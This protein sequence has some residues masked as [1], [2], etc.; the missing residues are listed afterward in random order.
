MQP[1][2]LFLA[3]FIP[4]ILLGSVVGL[5]FGSLLVATQIPNVIS[6]STNSLV[7]TSSEPHTLAVGKLS[8]QYPEGWHVFTTAIY[9]N[10]KR[11]LPEFTARISP[12]PIEMH[13]PAEGST[14]SGGISVYAQD[15]GEA[16]YAPYERDQ[17]KEYLSDEITIN[18]Q[19]VT[20]LRLTATDDAVFIPRY[21]E[22]LFI[23]GYEVRYEYEKPNE[24]ND[25]N[26]LLVKNS[27]RLAVTPTAGYVT[28][29]YIGTEV[30]DDR[31]F[32]GV[33][34]CHIFAVDGGSKEILEGLKS[35]EASVTPMKDGAYHVSLG[36]TIPT[37]VGIDPAVAGKMWVELK[38]QPDGDVVHGCYSPLHITKTEDDFHPAQ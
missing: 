2:S 13:S 4:G 6:T 24:A 18:G 14:M 33:S 34:T 11:V 28:G 30:R 8:L 19:K 36:E 5:A 32:A 23:G 20:R 26:W 9:D 35:Y 21:Q 25:P 10:P 16:I 3:H 29:R 17:Y 7:S 15:E 12:N 22:V 38:Q 31:P 37:G 27:L 1:K